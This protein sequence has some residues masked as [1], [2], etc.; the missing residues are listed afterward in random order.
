MFEISA[1]FL[2]SLSKI[3]IPYSFSYLPKGSF[4][5]YV[6]KQRWVGGQSIV[7]AHKENGPILF[8]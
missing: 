7:Y 1:I 2:S 5:N 4:N 3:Q 6:N 8:D